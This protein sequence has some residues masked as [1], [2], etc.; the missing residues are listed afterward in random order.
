MFSVINRNKRSCTLNFTRPEGQQLLR[1][2]VA[3]SDIVMENFSGGVL[4]KYGLAYDDLRKVRPDLIF[5]SASGLGRSGPQR[6]ALAYGSLLQGYSGRVSLIGRLNPALEAMGILPAW[7]DPITALWEVL[8]IQAALRH[9]ARTGEGA[10]IDLSMLESTVALLPDALLRAGLAH[11]G[12][13]VD[14]S[15]APGPA[16]AGCFRCAGKDEWLAVS[17][18]T[19]AQWRS[20]AAAMDRPDLV[21][22]DAFADS[23]R[24][25]QAK[26]KLDP[27]LAAWLRSQ[28]AIEAE[29]LLQSRGIPAARSRAI[30]DLVTD[31]H[32]KQ[33]GVFRNC[34]GDWKSARCPGWR[35]TDGAAA[36]PRLRRSV[37]TTPTCSA[38]FS[39]SMHRG[40]R[41]SKDAGVIR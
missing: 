10:F 29:A 31:E 23:S 34:G 2:L 35:K 40:G 4:A 5:V 28:S 32:L 14:S 12:V 30:D 24:R 20:L 21:A 17:V 27:H 13:D 11:A 39:A 26:A 18:R 3:G 19:D 33:R 8:A 37:R 38:R 22:A 41:N 6:D 1:D 9:K 7:T 25:S 15:D 16:P 36:P